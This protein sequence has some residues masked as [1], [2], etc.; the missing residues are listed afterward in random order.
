MYDNLFYR[1][2]SSRSIRLTLASTMIRLLGTRVVYEDSTVCSPPRTFCSSNL[3]K[4]EMESMFD[5]SASEALFDRFLFV[6][7]GLL[8]NHQPC[9]LK[10]RPVSKPLNESPKDFSPFD[11]DSA[12]SL[13]NELERMQLPDTVRW[14]IQAAMPI[15]LPY[16]RCSLM[17]QPLAV[18]PAT[19]LSLLQPSLASGFTPG[20]SSTP[21]Q[22]NSI[23]M[24]KMGNTAQG[25]L[26][27]TPAAQQQQELD[28]T[29]IDPWMLLEDG[30]GSGPS[31]NGSSSDHVNL[32]AASWL[33]GAVRV[34]RTELTY[35]G[36]VD[37]DS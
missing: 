28:S 4:A 32:R 5:P 12:E 17:C 21:P 16:Q 13:Q 29:E 24:A 33:K 36:S 6:L 14:R 3:S 7:H 15:L 9:W 35:I 11:R 25:K 23:S 19:A 20:A 18:V 22:R 37:E 34:R 2:P 26:R 31:S 30:T 8:S 10:T 27:Q 1:E